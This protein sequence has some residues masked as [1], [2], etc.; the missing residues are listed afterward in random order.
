MDARIDA[1]QCFH[2]NSSQVNWMG[3]HITDVEAFTAFLR[4]PAHDR[5][6]DLAL[7]A[8]F[9]DQM[10]DLGGTG[11]KLGVL[12]KFLGAVSPIKS[13]QIGEAIA[14]CLLAE[15]SAWQARWPWNMQRDARTPRAS[16]PG[17]DLVGFKTAG[18]EVLLLIGEVKT[19]S[20]ASNPPG[21]MNGRNQG[22]AYQVENHSVAFSEEHLCLLKWLWARCIGNQEM[23]D[24]YKQ[25]TER[26]LK[27]EG[28]DFLLVGAMVRDTPPNELDLSSKGRLMG[29][30]I[31]APTQLHFLA[32]YTP[33]AIPDWP[34]LISGGAS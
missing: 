22:L 20:D 13:W 19:S 1:R 28:Q 9:Q 16:L 14:E 34:G 21:V 4:G 8:S 17:A 6:R 24:F 26:Y 12:E 2:G 23:E 5:V 33:C 29:S 27:S 11:M 15:G 7:D 3:Y 10:R 32:W 25:A 30:R 18:G 31:T